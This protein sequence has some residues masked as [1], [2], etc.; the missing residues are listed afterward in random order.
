M[1]VVKKDMEIVGVKSEEE[2]DRVRCRQ[3]LE[4]QC[5][6]IVKIKKKVKIPDIK[7]K[8]YICAISRKKTILYL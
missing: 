6:V 5:S 1:N 3:M 8:K 4:S 2:D 7:H